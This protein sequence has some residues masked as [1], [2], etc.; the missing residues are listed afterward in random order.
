MVVSNPKN[1]LSTSDLMA[2]SGIILASVAF[3]MELTLVPL[4]LAEIKRDFGLSIRKLSWVFNSYAIAVVVAISVTG[5]IGDR[6]AKGR[7][8]LFGVLLFLGGSVLSAVSE[9]YEF[10]VFGRV[11]QGLGGGL[12][13][14]LIPILLARAFPDAPGKILIIWGGLAGVVATIVPFIGGE[15]VAVCGWR[16]IFVLISIFASISILISI[17]VSILV[18]TM[19]SYSSAKFSQIFASPELYFLFAYIILTYGC[20]SYFL[21]YFPIFISGQSYS[22][23]FIA[24]FL[25]TMW[26]SFSVT[27]FALRNAVDG[28]RLKLV[29]SVAPIFIATG[30]LLGVSFADNSAALLVAAALVGVGFACCNAP[31]THLLLKLVPEELHVFS[32]SFDI[33]LA[34]LGGIVA[35]AFLSHAMPW[36]AG[37]YAVVMAVLAIASCYLCFTF[38]KT[39]K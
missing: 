21:F 9:S 15:V 25:A 8:F 4:I 14:P 7:I 2:V 19:N 11:L 17:R 13:S 39:A 5:A 32:A 3:V 24:L 22:G 18:P 12:F 23:D 6:V 27:S 20:L 30:Y 29:L 36:V 1:E 10:L 35:V 33:V 31:S 26:F 34:R 28:A 37:S 38:S 16:G